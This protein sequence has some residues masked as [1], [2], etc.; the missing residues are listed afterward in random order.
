MDNERQETTEV[1]DTVTQDGDTEV[2]RQTV[3]E[4]RQSDPRV[5]ASRVVWY[6]AGVIIALLAVRFVLLLLGANQSAA[7]VGMVYTLS[8]IFAWPFYGIF[9]QPTYGVSQFDSASV[10]AMVVYALVAWGVSKLFTIDR[11]Q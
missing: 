2:R 1:R 9:P 5:T 4:S 10:V 8:G 7:F 3:K 6:I 11:H